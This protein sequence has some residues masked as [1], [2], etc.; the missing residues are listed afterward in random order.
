MPKCLL[1]FYRLFSY[2]R[3]HTCLTRGLHGMGCISS[4]AMHMVRC[5]AVHMVRCGS[6]LYKKYQS[7][8]KRCMWSDA[9]RC[10]WSD[11]VLVCTKRSVGLPTDAMRCIWS[12][13]VLVCTKNQSDYKRC[14]VRCDAVHMVRSKASHGLRYDVALKYHAENLLNSIASYAPH[15]HR[16]SLI[17]EACHRES[18]IFV[19]AYCNL[20]RASPDFW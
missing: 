15:R 11:A 9:M 13:A 8:Y 2:L 5:D 4:E 3:F 17:W 12:D 18:H 6:C 1:L 19:V 14:M 10:I 16:K 20:Q 7:D